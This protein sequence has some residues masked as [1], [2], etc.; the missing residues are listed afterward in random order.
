MAW[1]TFSAVASAMAEAAALSPHA[2]RRIFSRVV[3]GPEMLD[4]LAKPPTRLEP[5]QAI[6]RM[7][8]AFVGPQAVAGDD[9]TRTTCLMASLGQPA[10]KNN[11]TMRLAIERVVE[12]ATEEIGI[13]RAAL[14]M[15]GPLVDKVSIDIEGERT[16]AAIA[17]LSGR[18]VW[19]SPSG[20]HPVP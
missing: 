3:T 16:L 14:H 17:G 18:H 11:R 8:G 19:D 9:S 13:P 2:D 15:G 1:T 20:G 6:E 10:L 5:A 12:I 4:D 7:T